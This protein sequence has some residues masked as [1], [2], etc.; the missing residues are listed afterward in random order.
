VNHLQ[1]KLS[2]AKRVDDTNPSYSKNP[3]TKNA[4]PK[5]SSKSSKGNGEVNFKAKRLDLEEKNMEVTVV[6]KVKPSE[7]RQQDKAEPTVPPIIIRMRKSNESS[8][9]CKAI[10]E[11]LA[12]SSEESHQAMTLRGKSAAKSP[13]EPVHNLRKPQKQALLE[14]MELRTDK[15]T[16]KDSNKNV[17]SDDETL[18]RNLRKR[19]SVTSESEPEAK[20]PVLEPEDVAKNTRSNDLKDCSTPSVTGKKPE[21]IVVQKVE[22]ETE[23]SPVVDG[24]KS[25]L[26]ARSNTKTAEEKPKGAIVKDAKKVK[27][28]DENFLRNKQVSRQ[29]KLSPTVP[30]EKPPASGKDK[31]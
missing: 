8:D 26:R 6:T 10:P 4:S 24:V 29:K 22:E 7:Q 21:A 16:E 28:E 19:K 27:A 17:I 30:P 11:V 12:A 5:S 23:T 20:K 13:E 25:G 1:N 31:R 9:A 18:K 15:N 14:P 3:D 2:D